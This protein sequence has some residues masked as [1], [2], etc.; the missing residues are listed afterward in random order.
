MAT[1]NSDTVKVYSVAIARSMNACTLL[2]I[3]FL[4]NT[5]F[6]QSLGQVGRVIKVQVN[7]DIRVAVNGRRWVMNPKGMV[8]APNQTPQ[9]D[10]LGKNK[11]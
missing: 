8:P 10:F 3:L 11:T 9:E 6:T 4:S 7:S 2:C 5:Q 1:N